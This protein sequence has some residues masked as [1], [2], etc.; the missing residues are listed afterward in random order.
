MFLRYG[1]LIFALFCIVLGLAFMLPSLHQSVTTL[2]SSSDKKVLKLGVVAKEIVVDPS[3]AQSRPEKLM[4]STMYEPLLRYDE[5]SKS[6]KPCLARNWGYSKDGRSLVIM[7]ANCVYF[8]NGR[9][10]TAQDIKNSWERSLRDSKD[11]EL[12]YLFTTIEGAD[13]FQQGVAD[14]IKGL[15]VI[16]R[17]TLRIYM[18]QPDSALVYKMTNSAFWIVDVTDSVSTPPGT[19]PYRLNKLDEKQ[20]VVKSFKNYWG[21]KPDTGEIYFEAFDD[22]SEALKSF[23]NGNLDYLDQV[24]VKEVA[25]LAKDSAW[26][27][28]LVR[29]PVLGFYAL[30]MNVNQYPFN[31]LQFRQALNYCIDRQHL[32]N[33]V[34]GGVGVASKGVF[35]VDLPGYNRALRGYSYNPELSSELSAESSYMQESQPPAI[36]LYFNSDPG[37]EKLIMACQ[38]QLENLGLNIQPMPMNW[39]D[40]LGRVTTLQTE[41][42]RFGWDA[43]YPDPDGFLYPLFHS[44]QIGISNFC[45]YKNPRLDNI[46]DDAR[47]ETADNQKRIKLLRRAEQIVIDDA[48]MI[49]LFQKQSVKMVN[50][51]VKGLQVDGMGLINWKKIELLDGADIKEQS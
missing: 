5:I 45:A 20:L 40:Y 18:N 51:R 43:D 30:G 37:Q 23:Q 29:V 6:L 2:T 4:A 38:A 50:P 47:K 32:I 49:W 21:T 11:L 22:E 24:P 16:D 46:L 8:H 34:M 10:M 9:Q 33:N 15:K 39:D 7:L 25:G 3:L 26:K 12:Q 31:E 27:D 1:R 17:Y 28:C 41:F 44:S 36:K 42:F 35:P 14:E 19:G 48:P 13:A